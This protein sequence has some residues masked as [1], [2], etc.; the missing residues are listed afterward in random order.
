MSH[1]VEI[2]L[3]SN[4]SV[5][6]FKLPKGIV[7]HGVYIYTNP[8]FCEQPEDQARYPGAMHI[9]DAPAAIRD[10]VRDIQGVAG[11]TDVEIDGSKL[12]IYSTTDDRS[13]YRNIAVAAGSMVFGFF[14][15]TSNDI[16]LRICVSEG[17]FTT[18][19]D[20]MGILLV[21]QVLEEIG[22]RIGFMDE[23]GLVEQD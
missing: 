21:D 16:Q 4:L 19:Y 10:L 8:E 11:V 22:Q 6:T 12:S 9:D 2:E 5:T 13:T 18:I 7:F 3:T 20:A 14:S 23:L 17:L 15:W 1:I